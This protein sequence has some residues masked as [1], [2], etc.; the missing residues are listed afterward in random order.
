MRTTFIGLLAAGLLSVPLHVSAQT[1]GGTYTV[2][3]GD[4]LSWIA[5]KLYKDAGK[6]T[7]IHSNNLRLIGEDP[8]AI[9]VGQRLQLACID[10]LPTGLDG[11][12]ALA[13]IQAA[14]AA[15]TTEDAPV[16]AATPTAEAVAAAV[17]AAQTP[18]GVSQ[19]KLLTADDFAPFTD[20]GLP[21]GGLLAD[22]VNVAMDSSETGPEYQTYWV[23]DWAAHLQPLLTDNVLD[24]GYPW[25]R[26]DCENKPDQFRCEN[27]HFSDPLFEVLIL[28]F[29]DASRPV[30]FSSDAD[31]PGKTLCRPA[32]YFTHDLEKND[33]LW[34]SGGKI[35]LKQPDSVADCFDML[36]SGEVD[37]VALNE[38]TGRAAI[39]SLDLAGKVTVVDTRPLSIE[40][41]HVVVPK[42]HPQAQEM[43]DIVN[44]GLRAMRD[45]GAYQ[46]ILDV[47]MTR[48]WEDF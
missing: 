27:F 38:F 3:S 30:S 35:T 12:T 20:R 42:S 31:I 13:D 23:N 33:R 5:D 36:T 37:A 9:R 46:R 22:V 8:N 1:C 14:T 40:G 21:N 16:T 29:T 32:G 39:K 25:Y 2:Q 6:W 10:G 48:I 26:P 7:A 24:M 47:H 44:S 43:L 19:V 15:K 28:L 45:N 34:V 4:A 11:G 41:L 17:V 18:A